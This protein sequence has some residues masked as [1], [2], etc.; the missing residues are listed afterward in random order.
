MSCMIRHERYGLHFFAEY[1]S[2]K[3]LR[4]ARFLIIDA[5]AM[6]STAKSVLTDV[7][8]NFPAFQHSCNCPIP[9]SFSNINIISPQGHRR[10]SAGGR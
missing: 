9:L 4:G 10:G 2:I 5:Q 1:L 3:D 6:Y 8:T 7:S